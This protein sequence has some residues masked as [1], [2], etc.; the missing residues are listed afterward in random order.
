MFIF[1]LIIHAFIL[2]II[3]LGQPYLCIP[4][5][6][7]CC[8]FFFLHCWP[9]FSYCS[10]T[11]PFVFNTPLAAFSLIQ[12]H[13]AAKMSL[14]MSLV[15]L[16]KSL[17]SVN[18]AVS[19]VPLLFKKRV[20]SKIY[21]FS[22]NLWCYILIEGR[23][24]CL[25]SNIVD[26]TCLVVISAQIKCFY[27]KLNKHSVLTQFTDIIYSPCCE[28]LN[29]NFSLSPETTVYHH[30]KR[31][32][33]LLMDQLLLLMMGQN[34][35]KNYVFFLGWAVTSVS[36]ISYHLIRKKNCGIPIQ[37]AHNKVCGCY[38]VNGP[39]FAELCNTKLVHLVPT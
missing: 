26:C 23:Y 2:I 10:E 6:S 24:I 22:F 27:F 39:C 28:Q 21:I 33:Y 17:S 38:K 3:P 16:Y 18:V 4:Q 20:S 30:T 25:L 14:L 7:T 29:R 5:M 1:I 9:S 12:W 36:V 8:V 34:V 35:Y 11:R 37:T 15:C 19:I 13:T 31:N 32:A